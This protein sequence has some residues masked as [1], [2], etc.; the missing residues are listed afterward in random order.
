[1]VCIVCIDFLAL[2]RYLKHDRY[3]C[4][5]IKPI[6]DEVIFHW[7]KFDSIVFNQLMCCKVY[8]KRM[9][10]RVLYTINLMASEASTPGVSL[11]DSYGHN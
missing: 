6:Y 9:L 7:L 11:M 5:V 4:E 1:M 8:S 10:L 2:I 3:S